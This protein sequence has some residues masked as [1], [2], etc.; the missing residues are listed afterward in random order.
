[1]NLKKIT[2][3]CG[4]LALATGCTITTPELDQKGIV[5]DGQVNV[6]PRQ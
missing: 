2:L 3:G 5:S 4:I 6:T 1:M